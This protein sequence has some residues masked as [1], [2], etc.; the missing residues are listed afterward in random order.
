[1]SNH[2]QTQCKVYQ[3]I[4]RTLV[5]HGVEALFGIMG[6]ANLFMVDSFI[7]DAGGRFVP[8]SH[9]GNAVLMAH[10]YAQSHN[11]VG[12]ATVTHGPG[13]TNAVT[14]VVE[15]VHSRTPLVLLAGDTSPGNPGH[16][17]NI[18]QEALIRSTGAGFQPQ[19]SPATTMEDIATA[20]YRA[21]VEHRPV[22]LNMPLEY[23]WAD[24]EYQKLVRDV[25]N[26]RAY[27]PSSDDLDNA[28]GLI[29]GAKRPVILAGRGAM[30][31]RQALLD[32]GERIEAPL[33]TTLR[34][35]DLFHG[36]PYNLGLYGSLSSPV[37]L[38]EIVKSDCL[39]AFGASLNSHT[40]GGGS[41]EYGTLFDGKRV[42]QVELEPAA[43]GRDFRPTV[44][45]VG[46]AA[47]TAKRIRELLD[48]AEIP[49]SG[50]R[51]PEL[52][53]TIAGD[54]LEPQTP[55]QKSPPAP[56]TV[57]IRQA[58]LRL[59]E[60]I[61]ENRLLVSDSG[62]FMREAWKTIAVETP[63]DLIH[64][65]GFAAVGAGFGTAIG[66]AVNPG[67][68]TVLVCGDGGFMMNGLGEL[69]T[70]VRE[71]LDLI[72]IVC[73]DGCYGAEY[74]QFH[75]R[76]MDPGNTFCQ[77]PAF[78]PLAESLGL[79]S[80]T[81]DDEASLETAAE[82]IGNRQGPMLINLILDPNRVPNY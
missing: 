33:A 25:P 79:Q 40:S 56:G 65:A 80:L 9:E 3:A 36:E 78:T 63:R 26:T 24:I 8:A 50:Y 32:L 62:R 6:D 31:A 74:R 10:G 49:G 48:E 58:L 1:M 55:G 69:Y 28:A 39:I 41:A 38:E 18:T 13:L 67:K 16:L 77:W 51:S 14:A 7:R 73:N 5:D 82:S 52:R 72:V 12:V 19:R 68:P 21:A 15:A 20:F 59:D 35:K 43:L 75:T 44:G 46:D 81:V 37:A 11:T 45:V 54:R 47:L 61:P 4:A 64:A 2:K 71:R 30:G 53:E 23:Q 60:A 66:A 22:V 57:D 34:A 17:Q 27:L 29:A 70:A 42:V 76:N